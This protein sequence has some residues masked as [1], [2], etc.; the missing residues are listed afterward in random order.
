MR[1]FPHFWYVCWGL[2]V[3]HSLTLTSWSPFQDFSYIKLCHVQIET[4]L[5]FYF[6]ILMA[7]IYLLT[8]LP[9]L[10]HTG[11][12]WTGVMRMGTFVLFLILKNFQP[13]SLCVM[14]LVG[15]SHMPFIRLRYISS[16]S[17]LFKVFIMKNWFYH[18]FCQML[19]LNLLKWS[20]DFTFH[21]LMRCISLTDL[22]MF[23]HSYITGINPTYNAELIF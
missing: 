23:K 21:P 9:W 3:P 16:I 12:C 18:E 10:E 11:L 14:L 19:L 13:F 8:W 20:W 4:V 5:L 17:N 7:F 22:G 15:I 6:P 2:W 1:I